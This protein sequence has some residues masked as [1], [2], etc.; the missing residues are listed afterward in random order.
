MY[1]T[2]LS[3][4]KKNINV[5]VVSR[6]GKHM[7]QHGVEKST[8]ADNCLHGPQKQESA[9]INLTALFMKCCLPKYLSDDIERLQKRALRIIYPWM[10]YTDS[11]EES[12]LPRLSERR[13]LLTYKLFNEITRD[14]SHKLRSLLPSENN[15]VYQLRRKRQ[16]NVPRAKT[17]QFMNSFIVSNCKYF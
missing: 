12:C 9:G 4:V 16:L 6:V 1:L 7:K 11:L 3:R 2:S 5:K 13:Q 14:Q 17:D 10:S 8:I 15:C